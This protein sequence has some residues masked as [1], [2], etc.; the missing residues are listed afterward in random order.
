[1]LQHL[2]SIHVLPPALAYIYGTDLI[3][4][5]HQPNSISQAAIA[6]GAT[7][8][9]SLEIVEDFE[10]ANK[11]PDINRIVTAEVFPDVG[12][13]DPLRSDFHRVFQI[14]NGIEFPV[15]RDVEQI[16]VRRIDEMISYR[17]VEKMIAHRQEKR[18]EPTT[19]LRVLIPAVISTSS[20]YEINGRP[21]IGTKGFRKVLSDPRK[22]EPSPAIRIT[23][24]EGEVI[25]RAIL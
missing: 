6:A 1:M 5:G 4:A 13:A 21:S 22:R 12:D 25:K 7:G 20:V 16:T 19:K 10:W 9:R 11:Q 8:L 15:H 23:A 24:S 18:S 14:E 3:I 17:I 2:R